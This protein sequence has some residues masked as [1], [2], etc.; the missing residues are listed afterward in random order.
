[1]K[2]VDV[3]GPNN[4]IQVIIVLPT[5]YIVDPEDSQ[6]RNTLGVWCRLLTSP[7]RVYQ[8]LHCIAAFVEPGETARPLFRIKGWCSKVPPGLL[9]LANAAF[10]VLHINYIPDG[11]LPRILLSTNWFLWT[12][13]LVIAIHLLSHNDQSSSETADRRE[14][15]RRPSV[16]ENKVGIS[17]APLTIGIGEIEDVA[18]SCAIC[19]ADL[20]PGDEA[21]KLPCGHIFHGQCI[22]QWLRQ[23]RYCPLRCPEKLVALKS[24]PQQEPE[25]RH[26]ELLFVLPGQVDSPEV[27][28]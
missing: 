13:D 9:A 10:F 21:Q 11:A 7:L 17:P 26:D 27:D 1:M 2:Q 23:S 3:L 18:L 14:L 28:A 5:L 22:T 8:L 16:E 20:L 24:Q 19:L 4:C 6:L 15:S 25:P 12:V